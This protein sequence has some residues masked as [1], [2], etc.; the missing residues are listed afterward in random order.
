MLRL[1]DPL[2]ER[3]ISEI[4]KEDRVVEVHAHVEKEKPFMINDGSGSALVNSV[5]S[6]RE[7]DWIRVIGRVTIREGSTIPEIDPIV[8]R[9]ASKLDLDLFNEL[10]DI[11]ARLIIGGRDGK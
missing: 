10:K 9:D 3:N 4:S 6:F 2:K 1:P 11:K 8:I 7:G 5:C